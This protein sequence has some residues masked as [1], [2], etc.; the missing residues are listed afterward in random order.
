MAGKQVHP[1]SIISHRGVNLIERI[2]L[3]MGFV[4]HPIGATMDAGIDGFIEL[5]DAVTGEVLN[6]LLSVQSKATLGRFRAETEQ[7]FEFLCGERDLDYWL[8]GNAPVLLIVSRLHTGEAYW[9]SI[10]DYFADPI[11][12]QS[13][14]V[15]F[16]KSRDVFDASC[17]PSLLSLGLSR[18]AGIHLA[19][20]PKTETLYSNLLGL[21]RY[22]ER[23]FVGETH[24]SSPGQAWQTLRQL[25]GSSEGAWLFR[26]RQLTA[27]EDLREY[28]WTEICDQGTVEEF[29]SAEWA[30]ADDPVRQR[31]F[32]ELLKQTLRGMLEPDV[33]YNKD[34]TCYFFRATRDGSPR[35]VTYRN[36]S[37]LA[38]RAVFRSYA[39]KSD[40]SRSLYCRH[41]A[42]KG[43]FQRIEDQWFLEMTPTYYFT[44]DGY[45]VWLFAEDYLSGIKRRE[46]NP[47]VLGQLLMWASH[48]NGL[49][50][51]PG[52]TLPLAFGRLPTVELDRGI[53][54]RYWL[55]Q[56]EE[57]TNRTE[58]EDRADLPLFAGM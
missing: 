21:T 19:P 38:E 57:R 56:D 27:F 34:H 9:T 55:G 54:D 29:D 26:G 45:Q 44:R 41:S 17:K 12:R 13:R 42:F 6:A 2:V 46:R 20:P 1:N 32:V 33:G 48:L 25:G 53:N 8:S 24:C 51:T 47:A 18:D 50:S 5:R 39:A 3:Q 58:P 23:V 4:W 31:K 43:F 10:R 30:L 22:P 52:P 14:I 11:R 35:T 37:Q 36:H 16:D 49:D 40:A 28:P 7:S 15:R